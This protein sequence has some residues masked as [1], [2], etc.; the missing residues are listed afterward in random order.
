ML[1]TKYIYTGLTCIALSA[2]PAAG[3]TFSGA[4]L[5]DAD[6][7]KAECETSKVDLYVGPQSVR[8]GK[9]LY[10]AVETLTANGASSNAKFVTVK[11]DQSGE[12]YTLGVTHGLAVMDITAPKQR[13]RMT[14]SAYRG[15]AVSAPVEILIG[16]GA[17]SPFTLR[18]RFTGDGMTLRSSELTD[19]FGNL[20]ADGYIATLTIETRQSVR[21]IRQLK[22]ESGQ[23]FTHVKCAELGPEDI[24]LVISA[25]AQSQS[26]PLYSSTCAKRFAS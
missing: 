12:L 22:I 24:R 4:C 2:A 15:D 13:G 16:S 10:I 1:V 26:I 17:L 9:P 25:G 19:R 21:K 6:A 14:F 23:I 18:R 11:N 5:N 8:P 20:M 7:I 3:K